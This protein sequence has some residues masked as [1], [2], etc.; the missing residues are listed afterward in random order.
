[1]GALNTYRMWLVIPISMLIPNFKLQVTTQIKVFEYSH[2]PQL[3]ELY[4]INHSSIAEPVLLIWAIGAIS[5]LAFV[6]IS[7]VIK[8]KALQL[9][10]STV[11]NNLVNKSIRLSCYRS[12]YL[13]APLVTGLICKKLIIPNKFEQLYNDEQQQL[14]LKHELNHLA[15]KDLYWNAL[16]LVI[17]FVFWF[18]PLF[19]LGYKNFRQQQELAC[20]QQVLQNQG[21]SQKQ[22]YARAMLVASIT[23]SSK[24]LT[25]LNYNEEIYMKERIK[26]L[27]KH[28]HKSWRKMLPNLIGLF[29]FA[30]VAHSALAHNKQEKQI[31]THREAPIYPKVAFENNIQGWVQ[32][33][34]D[35][36]TDGSVSNAKVTEALPENVFNEAALN[37]IRKWHYSSSKEKV[38]NTSVQINFQLEQSSTE[39]I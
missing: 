33:Q 39:K 18:N 34:F 23:T 13:T 12:R 35:I 9:S 29:I 26:Q 27:N 8:I 6:I 37:A 16:A 22:E 11:P 28:K 30:T 17:L 15:V 31:P 1:M 20:D 21:T 10:P 3:T 36:N 4:K 24:A 2:I 19:W 38:F 25:Y 5:L 14:I 32:L 7:H